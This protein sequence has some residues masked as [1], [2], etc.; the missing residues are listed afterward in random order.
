MLRSV[1]SFMNT[2]FPVE[3]YLGVEKPNLVEILSRVR[4]C[5]RTRRR[6]A[7]VVAAGPAWPVELLF[8]RRRSRRRRVEG[9]A[10]RGG[11]Y[12]AG[13]SGDNQWARIG[14]GGAG[15]RRI[16]AAR[17]GGRRAV[18]SAAGAVEDTGG[19]RCGDERMV[20][21][22]WAFCDPTTPKIGRSRGCISPG[23]SPIHRWIMGRVQNRARDLPDPI[24]L[25]F[26][27]TWR[28]VTHHSWQPVRWAPYVGLFHLLELLLPCSVPRTRYAP[29]YLATGSLA[30]PPQWPSPSSPTHPAPQTVVL[31]LSV[32][33][34]SHPL[35]Q[36]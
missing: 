19:G 35:P 17:G 11:G 31:R 30:S 13:G 5:E 14:A 27:P 12:Y 1:N 8:S 10:G 32:L 29:L 2:L 20:R 26:R 18:D 28:Q 21:R 36:V 25:R 24:P 33:S 7:R 23:K 4:D 22:R 16:S 3:V 34:H 15:S 6:R 9:T